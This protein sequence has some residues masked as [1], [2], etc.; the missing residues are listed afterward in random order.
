[1]PRD[2]PRPDVRTRTVPS[3]L[4]DASS[5]AFSE[6]RQWDRHARAHDPALTAAAALWKRRGRYLLAA[7]VL[8]LLVAGGLYETEWR[9]IE[10]DQAPILTVELMPAQT[11]PVRPA[12]QAQPPPQLAQASQQPERPLEA[13]ADLAF[14]AASEAPPAPAE[15]TALSSVSGPATESDPTQVA[16]QASATTTPSQSSAESVQSNE[17]ALDG[18]QA[19]QTWESQVLAHLQRNLRY[20]EL[21]LQRGQEDRVSVT[22]KVDRSGQVLARNIIG[23]RGYALL[24]QEVLALIDRSNPLPAP[25][26]EVP[27]RYLEFLVPIEFLINRQTVRIW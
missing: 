12:A 6:G 8:H 19:E 27:D 16:T 3:V 1:M 9:L 15:N 22:I 13:I 20:P 18:V 11:A 4:R 10:P 17:Q 23:S 7:L 14:A 2:Q 25:P 24:D 5:S 21:A 26:E